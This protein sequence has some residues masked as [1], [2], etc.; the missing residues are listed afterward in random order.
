[1]LSELRI[2]PVAVAELTELFEC[3]KFSV[4]QIDGSMKTRAIDALVAVREDL[5]QT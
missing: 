4:H 1:V 3:A 5:A 2:R